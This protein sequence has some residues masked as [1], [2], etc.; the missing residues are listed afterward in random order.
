MNISFLRS[1]R[2]GIYLR[3]LKIP[4]IETIIKFYMTG[5]LVKLYM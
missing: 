4:S 3:L 1:V 2:F 5:F